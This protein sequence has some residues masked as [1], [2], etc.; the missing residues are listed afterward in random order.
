MSKINIST[1]LDIIDHEVKAIKDKIFSMVASPENK[2]PD[3]IPVKIFCFKCN[4]SDKVF[5]LWRKGTRD[6]SLQ[7]FYGVA[8]AFAKEWR[9]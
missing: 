8:R 7:K 9:L 2:G 1:S 6:I 5:Y 4:I 3:K